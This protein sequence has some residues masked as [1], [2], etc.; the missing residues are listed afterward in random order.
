MHRQDLFFTIYL[1]IFE[2][3]YHLCLKRE[4][5]N[6]RPNIFYLGLNNEHNL[7]ITIFR[8]FLIIF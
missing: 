4:N 6:N 1:A 5:V 3:N 2:P 8:Q 7:K